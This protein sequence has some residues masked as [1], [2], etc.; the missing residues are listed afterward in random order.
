MASEVENVSRAKIVLATAEALG[1]YLQGARLLDKKIWQLR[2]PELEGIA[3]ATVSAFI[4]AEAKERAMRDAEP[5]AAPS[6]FSD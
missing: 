3:N 4:V 5:V 1:E 2:M 6:A